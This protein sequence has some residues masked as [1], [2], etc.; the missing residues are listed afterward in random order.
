[1]Y[2]VNGKSVGIDN[3]DTEDRLLRYVRPAR[4][5]CAS[6][7]HYRSANAIYCGSTEIEPEILVHRV[8]QSH[9]RGQCQAL[10][11]RSTPSALDSRSMPAR[12]GR[13]I[14]SLA[15]DDWWPR[16]HLSETG[17][18]RR[19]ASHASTRPYGKTRQAVFARLATSARGLHV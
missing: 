16:S 5:S 8:Q 13:H 2:A 1:M 7:P 19:R 4:L 9:R 3:F 17:S 15:H 14:P 6:R 10:H 18:R 11:V 12:I